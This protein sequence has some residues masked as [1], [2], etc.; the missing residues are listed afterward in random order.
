MVLVMVLVTVTVRAHRQRRDLAPVIS[1]MP[2]L[3]AVQAARLRLRR[4]RGNTVEEAAWVQ[5]PVR[6]VDQ[7]KGA[8]LGKVLAE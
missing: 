3:A 6:A 1:A 2:V 5:E 7:A 8:A 4:V